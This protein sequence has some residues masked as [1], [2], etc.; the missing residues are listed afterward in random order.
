[1]HTANDKIHAVV[2]GEIYDYDDVLQ[3][4]ISHGYRPVGRSDSELVLALYSIH[5]APE[6]FDHLRGEFAFVILDEREHKRKIVAGRDRFG[7]KPL[8]WTVQNDKVLFASE[9][10]AFLG[11]GWVPE[12]DVQG[13]VTSGWLADERTLFKG[14]RKLLPG[15][16]MEL[17]DEYGLRIRQYWDPHYPDKVCLPSDLLI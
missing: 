13:I 8:F 3:H 4:C 1:M 9:A 12:W 11:L 5:G 10:K 17:T 15:R 6:M 7:V 16:W 14:V 2:N